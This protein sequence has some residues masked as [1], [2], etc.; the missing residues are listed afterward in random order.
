MAIKKASKNSKVE[1]HIVDKAGI[2][3]QTDKGDV[4]W[5]A[6]RGEAESTTT[7]EDDK[8]EGKAVLV[9]SFDFKANPAA[10]LHA[11]PSKQELFNAHANQIETILW[12]D[13]L[14]VMPEIEPRLILSKKRDG[15]R[16]VVGAE[17]AK[18]HLLHQRPQMLTQIA[19]AQRQ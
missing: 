4:E 9:R 14:Q 8:G 6:T 5:K 19:N 10:F 1:D 7:F 18:G 13:G 12:K 15:Y 17:P 11:T 2:T 16:I 3:Q